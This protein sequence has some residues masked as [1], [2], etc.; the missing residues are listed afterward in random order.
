MY[1]VSKVAGFT[2]SIRQRYSER[3]EDRTG[4]EVPSLTSSTQ[5]QFVDSGT[6][7]MDSPTVI[8]GTD[9]TM[10]YRQQSDGEE[11]EWLPVR[12]CDDPETQRVCYVQDDNTTLLMSSQDAPQIRYKT[13]AGIID[14][15]GGEV[16]DMLESFSRAGDWFDDIFGGGS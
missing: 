15:V 14:N 11:T 6:Y 10:Q 12:E 3:I 8:N 13:E 16:E 4:W 5:W 7:S 1:R 2:Y 9:L